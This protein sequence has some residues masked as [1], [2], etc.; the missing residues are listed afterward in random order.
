MAVQLR[1]ALFFARDDKNAVVGP[2]T[3]H[4]MK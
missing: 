3:G 1:L 4:E 2:L